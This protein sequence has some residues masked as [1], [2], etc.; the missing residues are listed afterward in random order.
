MSSQSLMILVMV[1][2]SIFTPMKQRLK[3]SLL[4]AMSSKNNQRAEVNESVMHTMTFLYT[5]GMMKKLW[6]MSF[7]IMDLP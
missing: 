3:N 7:S 6:A 1:H 2:V 5:R 4:R